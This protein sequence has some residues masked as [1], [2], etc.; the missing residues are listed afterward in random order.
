MANKNIAGIWSNYYP[1]S[2]GNPHDYLNNNGWNSLLITAE[3]LDEGN[4]IKD[5]VYCL[6]KVSVEKKLKS[7]SILNRVI[8]KVKQINYWSKYNAFCEKVLLENKV[9]LIHAHFGYTA[10]RILPV[11][12]K[13]KIPMVVTFYGV[14]GS[15]M[16][17]ESKWVKGYKEMFAY[18]SKII[19]L[20]EEVKKRLINIGCEP[21]KI[22]I[23]Q[24]PIDLGVYQYK[25]R[26]PDEV[27]KLII[28]ARFVEKKGYKFLIEAFK[29]LLDDG[30]KAELTIVGYGNYKSRIEELIV[31]EEVGNY[32]NLKDTSLKPG[33]SV[34]F[35]NE[36]QK[37]DIFVLPSISSKNGDDEGGP[38]L[39]LVAAQAAGLP[40]VCT[41]FPGAEISVVNG[42]NGLICLPESV[43]SLYEKL[44]IMMDSSEKWNSM[45]KNG[46]DLVHNLFKEE[47]QFPILEKILVSS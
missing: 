16:L 12:K 46:S 26:V 25:P 34:F 17:K 36:L 20:C 33:F 2:D 23:W 22:V 47:K 7:N 4:P 10:V 38:S 29:K 6:N 35:N 13:L 21:S 3:Y 31:S 24:I 14:D 44:V 40:V 30:R 45:G 1:G 9:D 32:V 15:Q 28:G 19:V 27:F 41:S 11:V 42:E 43:D 18:T 37:H 39:T 5:D 8:G